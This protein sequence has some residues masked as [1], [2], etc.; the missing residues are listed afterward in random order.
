LFAHGGEITDKIMSGTSAE[1]RLARRKRIEKSVLFFIF[2]AL[3]HRRQVTRIEEDTSW[4][5]QIA[6][7]GSHTP[8]KIGMK[9]PPWTWRVKTAW[10]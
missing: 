8:R 5:Q 3:F 6:H 1:Q 7:P 2:M 10:S 9:T 4:Y